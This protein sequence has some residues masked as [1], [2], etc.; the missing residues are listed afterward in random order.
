MK[1]DRNKCVQ[2]IGK[3]FFSDTIELLD[4]VLSDDE[5]NPAYS[6]ITTLNRLY[7]YIEFQKITGEQGCGCIQSLF[8]QMGY[9]EKAYEAFRAKAKEEYAIYSS[10]IYDTSFFEE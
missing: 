9:S 5:K 3:W 10:E 1:M 2:F 4:R 6:A 7:L 8:R